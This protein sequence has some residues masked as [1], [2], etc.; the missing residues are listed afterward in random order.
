VA[1]RPPRVIVSYDGTSNDR[2]ALALGRLL[3]GAGASLA[4]AYVRHARAAGTGR[5]RLAAQ[6]AEAL[7][8]AGADVLGRPDIPQHVVVSASTPVGLRDLALNCGADLIVFGSEYRTASG[9]V[10]PQASARRLLDGGPVALAI[11]PAGFA[12]RDGYAVGTIAAIGEDGDQCPHETAEAIASGLGGA[13]V[14]PSAGEADL[15]VVGSKPGTVNGRVTI[16]AAA[17]YVIELSRCPVLVLPRGVALEF[18]TDGG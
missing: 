16:S 15:V 11:A 7:L 12:E 5:E 6:E 18:H 14:G 9:H 8:A 4:L 17:E 2:D 13:V 1:V 3:T 10:D